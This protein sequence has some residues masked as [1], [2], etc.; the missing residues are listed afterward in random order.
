MVVMLRDRGA[1]PGSRIDE[2][3][4]WPDAARGHGAGIAAEVIGRA[5]H[6][7]DG[8]AEGSVAGLDIGIDR[9]EIVEQSRTAIPRHDG[10]AAHDIVAGERRH[11]NGR[12]LLEG[13]V[14]G[15]GAE[16][17]LDGAEG[18]LRPVDLVHLVDG[19]ND[20]LDADEIA[21]RGVAAGLALHAMARIDQ[22]DR[23]VGV[24]TRRS[25]CCGYIARGQASR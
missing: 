3:I 17:L 14:A 12:D 25:P 4:A 19:E 16:I 6:E 22:Q 21:D 23:H 8:E 24:A 1:K 7:L 20:L 18:L 9:L 11:R 5:E 13:E 10:G 2:A 15:E